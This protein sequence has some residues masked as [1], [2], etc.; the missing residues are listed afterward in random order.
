MQSG[1][2]IRSGRPM[3]C[4]RPARPEDV[5]KVLLMTQQ[6][7]ALIVDPHG[8]YGIVTPRDAVRAFSEGVA[9]SISVTEWVQ[10]WQSAA[11][12]RLIESTA[13]V[14]DA[15]AV[16]TAHNFHHLVVVSPG[17]AE[18]VG[19]VSSLDLA[20]CAKARSCMLC[21]IGAWR[22]ELRRVLSPPARRAAL[23]CPAGVGRGG[24]GG[25]G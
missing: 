4:G 3:G 23:Q 6:N 5:I 21:L 10:E 9:S 24:V 8:I 22:R 11:G 25:A 18:A 16:M 12:P 7:S 13:R 1:H 19:T 14:A 15:A 2:L 20:L 17:T